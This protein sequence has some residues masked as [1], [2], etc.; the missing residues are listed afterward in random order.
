MSDPR[1]PGYTPSSDYEAPESI[2]LDTGFFTDPINI[3]KYGEVVRER[4]TPPMIFYYVKNTGKIHTSGFDE[5]KSA[6]WSGLDLNS[7][8]IYFF[9]D[10]TTEDI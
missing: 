3:V 2:S 4:N 1:R 9:A 10:L 7:N 6:I 8:S 5:E